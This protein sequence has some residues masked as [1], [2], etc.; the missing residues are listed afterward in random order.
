MNMLS[1]FSF[2][3]FPVHGIDIELGP[4]VENGLHLLKTPALCLLEKQ[5]DQYRHDDVQRGVENE[6]IS[7]HFCDHVR[8]D[9]RVHEVEEPLGAH[10]NGSSYGSDAGGEDL[11]RS[12]M[13]FEGE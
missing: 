9:E 10:T 1:L 11:Q 4:A 5:E 7:V 2:Y 12:E 3:R 8:R 13:R 6:Y